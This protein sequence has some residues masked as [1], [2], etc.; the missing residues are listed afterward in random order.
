MFEAP[1]FPFSRCHGQVANDLEDWGLGEYGGEQKRRRRKSPQCR[2]RLY[3]GEWWFPSID[4]GSTARLLD[5]GR[6]GIC[7][8]QREVSA[9]QR[10]QR[11]LLRLE[12]HS[13]KSWPSLPGCH[14][15]H[16]GE[17]GQE[18]KHD[19]TFMGLLVSC[20]KKLFNFEIAHKSMRTKTPRPIQH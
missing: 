9:R 1:P 3:A 19:L 20:V 17:R 6:S 11:K 8:R 4:L 12:G 16:C 15:S 2:E 18:R 14:T 5:F 10:M 7:T 13:L